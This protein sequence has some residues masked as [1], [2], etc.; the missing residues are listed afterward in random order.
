MKLN[1][2]NALK[3]IVKSKIKQYKF[4]KRD[5]MIYMVKDN[6]I[7]GLFIDS[8]IRETD[9]KPIVHSYIEYKPLWIDDLLWEILDMKSNK[10]E[11]DSLRIMGAFTVPGMEYS[12][13]TIEFDGNVDTLEKLIDGVFKNFENNISLFTA[14]SSGNNDDTVEIGSKTITTTHTQHLTSQTDFEKFFTFS[15]S[16]TY[17]TDNGRYGKEYTSYSVTIDIK[18]RL[19]GFV[20]YEG[21]LSFRV[22]ANENSTGGGH[23]NELI[24]VS[25]SYKGK[26]TKRCEYNSDKYKDE[27]VVFPHINEI[28]Y[29]YEDAYTLVPTNVDITVT[30]HNEGLSGDYSQCYQTINVTKYN[31]ESYIFGKLKNSVYYVTVKYQ[32]GETVELTANGLLPESK[33]DITEEIVDVYGTIDIYP[34]ATI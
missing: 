32:N 22:V 30:Y 29:Y 27:S 19:S 24:P 4:R 11:P 20:E 31:Y 33:R 16:S 13:D 28:G 18:P 14:C 2:E 6:M 26:A 25:V 5:Y 21:S 17:G 8:Y 34:N 7:Y 15:K 1:F 12:D 23:H 9:S 3:E 10:N